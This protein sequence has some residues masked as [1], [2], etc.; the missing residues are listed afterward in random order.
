MND[1][2]RQKQQQQLLRSSID[3]LRLIG[4][5]LRSFSKSPNAQALSCSTTTSPTSPKSNNNNTAALGTILD[6][7]Y[8]SQPPS[9]NH[10]Q[11]ASMSS[12]SFSSMMKNNN[13][14]TSTTNNNNKETSD[15]LAIDA[16][17]VFS[18]VTT[19]RALNT[20]LTSH[21]IE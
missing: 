7:R 9:G 12:V 2:H 5:M 13:N 14:E 1:Q 16:G 18:G 4:V 3:E 19:P 21:N 8:S 11:E 20:T 6:Q 17:E 15:L 10:Q